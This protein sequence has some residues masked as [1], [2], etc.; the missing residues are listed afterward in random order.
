MAS[1]VPEPMEKCAV[2]LASPISTMLSFTQ[3][4][5]R[6]VGKLRQI[7]RLVMSL[8]P[9]NSSANTRSMNSALSCSLMRSRPARSQVWGVVSSTQVEAP[10]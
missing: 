8:W 5:L 2:A 6:T 3:R 4:A 7:D 9:C 10:A 1:L